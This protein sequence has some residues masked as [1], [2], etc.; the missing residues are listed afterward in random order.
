MILP[1]QRSSENVPKNRVLSLKPQAKADGPAYLQ[2][3][4]GARFSH[5][6]CIPQVLRSVAEGAGLEPSKRVCN[7][8]KERIMG[9]TLTEKILELPPEPRATVEK[10]AAELIAAEHNRCQ[11]ER[12]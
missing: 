3:Q 8:F 12:E 9:K 1:L 5:G 4:H 6:S 7:S 10:L 2:D 11:R